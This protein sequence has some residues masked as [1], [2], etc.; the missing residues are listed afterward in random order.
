MRTIAVGN[1]KGGV[2]KTTTVVNLGFELARRG[3][4]VVLVD[5]DPQASLSLCLGVERPGRGLAAVLGD[6]EPGRVRLS[7][8][9]VACPVPGM[10][11][12]PSDVGLAGA[13]AGMERRPGREMLLRQALLPVRAD[14]VLIDCPPSLGLLT[15][16]ALAAAEEV[17]V[18]VK[19]EYLDLR[20]LVLFWQTLARVRWLN[21]G[22]RLAGVL[23][24]MVRHTV[25]HREM[26]EWLRGH[27]PERVFESVPESIRV[28]EAHSRGLAV[29]AVEEGN[30]VVRAYEGL[31][32]ELESQ[33]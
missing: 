9:V 15:V 10:W 11:L 32:R 33:R 5:A 3:R 31:A 12:V 14:Y 2:G 19:A 17:V 16:M 23:P 7:E 29:R 21:P 27:V 22:L 25:H 4:R 6:H 24:T 8:V 13:A 26:V 20:G 18:P 1:Q 28:G 30:P